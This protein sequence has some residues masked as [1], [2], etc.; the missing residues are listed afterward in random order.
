MAQ[1]FSPFQKG[2]GG[3]QQQSGVMFYRLPEEE[4]L[5]QQEQTQHYFKMTNSRVSGFSDFPPR[6]KCLFPTDMKK[7][8]WR[9]T[10]LGLLGIKH[11]PKAELSLKDKVQRER[12][13]A[14]PSDESDSSFWG[15]DP[16][17]VS[18]KHHPCTSATRSP[19]LSA[20]SLAWE[21]EG[22]RSR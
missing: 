7:V 5:R 15:K 12:E 21:E 9:P 17:P 8:S 19:V 14:G 4:T 11:L 10:K 1:R 20:T 16:R 3:I 2:D 6:N 13:T 22:S 18:L